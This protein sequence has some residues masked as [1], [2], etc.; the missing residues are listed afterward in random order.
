VTCPRTALHLHTPP[1]PPLRLEIIVFDRSQRI[2]ISSINCSLSSSDA[3]FPFR[4]K[5]HQAQL[6]G[7]RFSRWQRHRQQQEALS[8]RTR[9]LLRCDKSGSFW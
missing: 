9:T 8:Q 1:P 5:S 3:R 7:R 6:Q 4:Q 2:L